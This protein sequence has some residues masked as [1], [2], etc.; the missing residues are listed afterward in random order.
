[1]NPLFLA[2]LALPAI[3]YSATTFDVQVGF[4]NSTKYFPDKVTLDM[5]DT[6]RF[7]FV[8][9]VH[10][11][12]QE[13]AAAKCQKDATAAFDIRQS[14]GSTLEYTFMK[15]GTFNYYS[16]TGDD[17]TK[18]M[19]GTVIVKGNGTSPK[20]PNNGTDNTNSTK[21]INNSTNSTNGTNGNNRTK[22]ENNTKKDD[23]TK[24]GIDSA[25]GADGATERLGTTLFVLAL[26]AIA[27]HC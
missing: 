16:S 8:S 6:V 10:T 1:M 11:V 7:R 13:S 5:G 18:G 21:N 2:L 17:C 3:I 9:G 4:D 12:T 23:K 20:P 27:Q 24:S 22:T 26:V 15:E 25:S 14:E 19:R